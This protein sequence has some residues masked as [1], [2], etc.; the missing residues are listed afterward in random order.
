MYAG[1]LVEVGECDAVYTAPLHPYTQA[2][3][4]AA[5]PLHPAVRRRRIVLSDEV[6][7][8]LQ[9]PPGCRF[10]PRCPQALPQCR[11]DEPVWREVKNGQA[12]ACHLY[13]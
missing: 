6:P 13:A 7:N 5:L 2:L 11:T 9:P 1:K 3:L 10:H 4:S 12:T 8:P